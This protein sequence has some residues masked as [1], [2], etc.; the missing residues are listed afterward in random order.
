MALPTNAANTMQKS[1][2]I[3]RRQQ[4]NIVSS[5]QIPIRHRLRDR[6]TFARILSMED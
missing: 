3:G 6:H 5:Y 2:P 4:S 1:R